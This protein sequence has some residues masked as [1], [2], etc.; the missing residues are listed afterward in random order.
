VNCHE[1]IADQKLWL[2]GN[3]YDN[4]SFLPEQH[5]P[6]CGYP[7]VVEECS[8]CEENSYAFTQAVSVFM[9]E[10]SAQ[11]MVHALKYGGLTDIA[12]WFANQMFK[13]TLREKTLSEVD[14]VIAVP[15]HKVRR[16]ERGF[17]QS[18]LIAQALATRMNIKYAKHAL[19]RKTY[20]MSQTML[21]AA[22]RKK[23]LRGA[24]A[25]G[26]FNPGGKSFLL[27]D[28]VFTTGTTVNEATKALLKAGAKQVYVM[29]ACHGL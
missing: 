2:C 12:D 13:T 26:R 7:S 15:L 22:S 6:K 19:K 9:Y 21:N 11:A 14:Y 27:I 3:C 5:C 1:R 25:I 18:D 20:T 10:T 23:N 17:N 8:N 16:R 28:D 29:T 24:F 4:L